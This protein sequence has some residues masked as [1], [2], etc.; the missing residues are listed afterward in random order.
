MKRFW[1][2]F[3]AASMLS[4]CS[5]GNPFLDD[6]PDT[7]TPPPG[8]IPADVAGDLDAATFVPDP[9][10]PR[11]VVTGV[12]YNGTPLPVEYDR[13]ATSATLDSPGGQYTAFTRQPDALNTHTTAYAREVAGTRGVL[14]VSGGLDGYYN[15]GVSYSR[16]GGFDRPAAN[17]ANADIRYDGEY[18]GLLNYPDD[19][20]ALL[21]VP[22]GT[23]PDVAPGQAGRVFGQARIDADF[24]TNRVKGLVYNRRYEAAG[25]D[26]PEN[27]E[28]APT[29]ILEDGSFAGEVTVAKQTKGTYGG[30][31]GGPEAQAVAG[32][33]FAK[34]HITGLARVEEYGLFVLERSN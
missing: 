22:P 31:F 10:N 28:I 26:I 25:L 13:T 24:S 27:L 12:A 20:A 19:G 2:G 3:A 34:D 18:V 5:G 7:G 9:T 33:L 15:G 16:S 14:V 29:D 17:P 23:D 4:A 11:L 1:L 6:D 8:N 21:P 32:G 30:T